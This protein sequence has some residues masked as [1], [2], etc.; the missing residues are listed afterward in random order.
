M[1][2]DINWNEIHQLDLD[3]SPEAHERFEAALKRGLNV[4]TTEREDRL[5]REWCEKVGW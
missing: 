2:E 1:G 5:L 4:K 3:T